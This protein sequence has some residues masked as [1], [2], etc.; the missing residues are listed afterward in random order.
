MTG[1]TIREV[2][3]V[4]HP[5]SSLTNGYLAQIRRSFVIDQ[6]LWTMSDGGLMASDLTSLAR[7]AWIPLA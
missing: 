3:F 1:Q 7:L 5:V 4:Q 6:T 2:G